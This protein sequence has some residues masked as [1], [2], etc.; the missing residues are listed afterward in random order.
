[1]SCQLNI[2]I[3]RKFDDAQVQAELSRVPFEIV[4][5]ETG[6][7]TYNINYNGKSKQLTAEQLTAAL[8]TKLKE[9]AEAA[10]NVKVNDCVVSVPSYFTDAER[11]ALLDSAKMSGLNVLKLMNDTTAT[12]LAYGIYKQDLPE[13]DKPS[14]NVVFVD[15]GHT[16]TQVAAASF[17]KGK[18]SMLASG[19][20]R[21]GGRNFDEE[22]CKHFAAEFSTK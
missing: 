10:L 6:A 16:G 2:H 1:M 21:S 7:S 5:G 3:F 9:T 22:M 19:F 20:S 12:A 8:F 17:N 15:C 14:R 18:L 4:K 13:P 11:R